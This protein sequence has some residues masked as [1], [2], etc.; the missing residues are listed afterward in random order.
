MLLYIVVK[1]ALTTLALQLNVFLDG[2]KFLHHS[3]DFDAPLERVKLRM[4]Y[5]VLLRLL[6]QLFLLLV[7]RRVE[8]ANFS[9]FDP[10]LRD[11]AAKVRIAGTAVLESVEV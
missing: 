9:L 4:Q 5:F 3:I 7:A 2:K 8:K 1:K 10:P 6:K 11:F